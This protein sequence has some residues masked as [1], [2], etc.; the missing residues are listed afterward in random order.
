MIEKGIRGGITHAINRY[1]KANNTYMKNYDKNNKSSHIQCFDANNLYG[2]VMSQKMPADGF[3]WIET[4][5]IDKKFNKF[6]KLIKNYDEES[7]EE[8]ILEVDTE[9]PKKLHDLHSDLPIS[10]ERMKINKCNKLVCN[11]SDKRIMLST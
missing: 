10:P 1:A 9:Y 11:L 8:Y 3:K 7:D 5:V 2:W 4:S 6:V